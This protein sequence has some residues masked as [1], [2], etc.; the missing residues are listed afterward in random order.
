MRKAT[1]SVDELRRKVATL[2]GESLCVSVN[3]GRRR[4]VKYRARLKGVYPS[5]FTLEIEN[6]RSLKSMSCSYNDLV[7][8]DVRLAVIKPRPSL[9]S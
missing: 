5:V 2:E 9:S 3:R 1:V 8:G 4:V 6:S 7:C